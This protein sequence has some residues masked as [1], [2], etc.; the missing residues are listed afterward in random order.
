MNDLKLSDED[1]EDL[2][3]RISTLCEQNVLNKVDY[4]AII[5]VCKVACE[6]RMEEIERVIGKPSDI[7]Q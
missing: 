2:V 1:K 6:R 3:N 4:V 7:I 5:N